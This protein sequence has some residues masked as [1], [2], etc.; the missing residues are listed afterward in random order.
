MDLVLAGFLALSMGGSSFA[1]AF[2]AAHGGGVAS[3]KVLASLFTLC[4]ILGAVAVGRPV[5][6]TLGRGIIPSEVF[7]GRGLTI[8]L[9][10]A[11]LSMGAAT[12]MRIPQ[13]TSLVT[14]A[15]IVGV[16]AA[17]GR[18]DAGRVVTMLPYWILLPLVGVGL[19]YGAARLVY[20]PR[21][22][23]FWVYERWVHHRPRL[24]FLIL[25]GSCWCAF[26]AGAN[27]VANVAGPFA[28]KTGLGMPAS[29]TLFAI[30]FGAGAWIF[31]GPLRT[32][33]A[34]VVPLGLLTASILSM[35]SGALMIAASWAGVPQSMV[36]LQMGAV[37]AVAGL[38]NGWTQTAEDPVVRRALFTWTINPAATFIVS[39]ILARWWL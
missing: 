36:M 2:G 12:L 23:N 30:L 20:P 24:R 6:S 37:I 35:V 13:T 32:V 4:V 15:A 18:W 27:N 22:G 7:L 38:K 5:A 9:F 21:R 16:G 34:Q 31:T 11:G 28:Q 19:T 17:L 25:A 26:S 10:S 1:A 33:G 3:S 14:V 39:F 29:L 8:V